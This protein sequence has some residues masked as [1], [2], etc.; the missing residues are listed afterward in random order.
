MNARH[1][2]RRSLILSALPSL[3]FPA[4]VR[5][6]TFAPLGPAAGGFAQ[7]SRDT[8]LR[9]P[10]DHGPHPAFRI[11]WWY[12]TANL[13]GPD[14]TAY[15]VQWTLFRSALST[16][17]AI[18]QAWLGHAALTTPDR[19]LSAER[20]ARGGTGQA[21]VTAEPFSARIDDWAL[22]GPSLSDV[23]M[24]AAG[25]D[26]AYDLALATDRPFV[27]QGDRGYSL[28]SATGVASHYYSQPFYRAEG[29]LILPDREVPVTGLAWL[30]RE[31]SSAPLEPGQLGWDWASLHLATG[32]KVMAAQLRQQGR[33]PFTAATWIAADG[34]PTPIPDGG[35]TLTPLETAE[36]AGRSVPVRWRIALPDRGLDVEIAAV[37]REAWMDLLYAYWE[38]PVTIEGSH[39]G[40][41]YLEMTGYE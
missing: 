4:L 17:D 16:D 34:S 11:E 39:A 13:T 31:W 29:R 20:M 27:L 12:V 1:P 24:T 6:Q 37:N 14:G 5:A 40:V 19:H 9:F 28:K 15:G 26:F 18:P 41:G 21:G 7:P 36:V 25:A 30:D 2:T 38:G 22:D 3:A 23:T 32:E 8:R 35:V 10:A 33:A